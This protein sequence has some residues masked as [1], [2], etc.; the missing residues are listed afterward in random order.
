MKALKPWKYPNS[1]EISEANHLILKRL[2]QIDRRPF[3]NFK[4]QMKEFRKHIEI[5]ENRKKWFA[6]SRSYSPV[7]Y[8]RRKL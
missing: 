1:V 8:R 5:V 4:D 2:A 6:I 3:Y 7:P